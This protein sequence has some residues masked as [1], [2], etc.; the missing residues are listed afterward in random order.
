MIKKVLAFTFCFLP[1]HIAGEPTRPEKLF[2][3]GLRVPHG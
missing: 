2:A 1:S 3:W